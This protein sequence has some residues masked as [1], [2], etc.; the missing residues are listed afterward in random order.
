M[1]E[2]EICYRI[3]ASRDARFD[4][5]FFVAVTSTRIYCR[6]SCPART[7]KPE[8]V[9]FYATA[10]AAQHAGFRAC[11]R[12]RPDASPGSPE[13]NQRAD[14]A[15][16]AMRLILDGVADREGVQGLARR[17]GYSGRQLHRLLVA[18]VGAGP[19]AL[20]RAQR[21]HTARVLL[22]TTGLPAGQVAFAAGFSSIRQFNATIGEVFAQT[23]SQLRQSADRW[24]DG[25]PTVGLIRLRLAY[26]PPLDFRALLRFLGTRAVPSVE[27]VQDETYMR[28]LS[29]PHGL[30]IAWV[31]Q[32]TD[33]TDK[34]RLYLHCDLELRDVRD[35]PAATE[36]M[37]RLFDLDADPLWIEEGLGR[38]SLLGPLVAAM[39][40]LRVPGTVEGE[41]LALRAVLGQQVSVAG[42][43]TLA[44]R[45]AHAYGEPLERPRGPLTH[46]FPTAARIAALDPSALAM[47]RAR[48]EALVRI[49]TV[50]AQRKV[51]LDP[52]A[53]RDAVERELLALRGIGPWTVQYIRM[54]AL[55]DPDA[56]LPSD[57]GVR[58]SLEALGRP[59]DPKA[60]QAISER[61]RPWR[62][63]AVQYLW[64]S[65]G[66]R[67]EDPGASGK[68]GVR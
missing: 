48:A 20:A 68:A 54:R 62:A 23:P 44:G 1:M 57:L 11:K 42:A 51:V 21:A 36:R 13:W 3:L 27:A 30:G 56:F 15:G 55:G 24:A 5:I 4:G 2:P 18:E 34:R 16:R 45:L 49:A 59:G 17:L 43:R 58:R 33:K 53:D 29:L 22:Q 52:A 65:L 35:L 46:A 37:R 6:P 28:L 26:R 47:P 41:E 8:N 60:A 66:L 67:P 7:P 63:Y 39:P 12:C 31:R 10:A 9:R 50:L 19:L 32:P 40:G 38:D 14:T 64:A 61:W 25:P